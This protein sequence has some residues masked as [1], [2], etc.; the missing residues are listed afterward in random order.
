ME[1]RLIR[2]SHVVALSAVVALAGASRASANAIVQYFGAITRSTPPFLQRLRT[3][4]NLPVPRVRITEA[5]RARARAAGWSRITAPAPFSVGAAQALL[6]TDGTVMIQDFCS[7]D[8]WS[9]TPDI[10]GSYVNGAWTQKASMPPNYAPLFNASAVLADG[11]LIVNGGEFNTGGA[12]CQGALTTLGAIYDPVAN[13]WS[14]VN[15]PNGWSSIGDASS[16]VL[17][18]G[19]YMLANFINSQQACSTKAR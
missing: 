12:S 1:A 16:V 10:H 9:L 7:S 11:K 5:D 15:A 13:T 6:M 14:P 8:W 3:P 18:D 4:P 19:T 2:P 17:P